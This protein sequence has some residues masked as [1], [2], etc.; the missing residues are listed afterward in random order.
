M[1]VEVEVTTV[2]HG[3]RERGVGMDLPL[4]QQILIDTMVGPT[5][6]HVDVGIDAD[7]AT[8]SLAAGARSAVQAASVASSTNGNRGFI[9]RT[10]L[11]ACNPVSR[12]PVNAMRT[13]RR[14][15]QAGGVKF[16]RSPAQQAW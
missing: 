5:P 7:V 3:E 8:A 1:V 13:P 12:S 11:L 9:A 10:P 15:D 2:E 4:A 6:E 14:P 16:L